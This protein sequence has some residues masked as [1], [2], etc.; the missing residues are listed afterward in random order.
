MEIQERFEKPDN[1]EPIEAEDSPRQ[2][3]ITIYRANQSRAVIPARD[4]GAVR[5]DHVV[6]P[7]TAEG[8]RR[9]GQSG[10]SKGGAGAVARVLFES[11]TLHVAYAWFKSGF[12]LPVHSHDS[13]CYYQIIAGSLRLGSKTLGKGDGMLVPA[14]V[15]YTVTPGAEGVEFLEIRPTGNYDTR[16]LAKTEKYWDRIVDRLSE[17]RSEWATEKQP[18]GLIP[19]DQA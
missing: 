17:R 12:P 3:A 16:F 15:A 9:F 18:Y 11:P 13:D 19:T 2:G 14:G 10:A 1:A 4:R 8:V 5:K 7:V 6:H